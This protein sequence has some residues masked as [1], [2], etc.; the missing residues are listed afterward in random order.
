MLASVMVRSLFDIIVSFHIKG[1]QPLLRKGLA[2]AKHILRRFRAKYE[3]INPYIHVENV[4]KARVGFSS[5]T[6]EAAFDSWLVQDHQN[7]K[8]TNDL[9]GVKF[10][11]ISS[12]RGL[13][14]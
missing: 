6:L 14:L 3:L 9:A 10:A 2:R 12:S 1:L 13:W 7:G 8:A 4:F 5:Q 11:S